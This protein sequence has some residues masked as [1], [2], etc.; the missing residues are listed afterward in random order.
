[1]DDNSYILTTVTKR[2]IDVDDSALEGARAFLGTSTMKD[3]V[4]EALRRAATQRRVQLEGAL[5]ALAD[6]DLSD[7][8]A[9]W[10]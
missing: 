6:T 5:D 7:R 4:N 10:R 1:M 9:G 8:A 3:T 2:L